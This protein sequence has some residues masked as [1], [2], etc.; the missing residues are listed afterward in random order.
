MNEFRQEMV[1]KARWS[2][3]EGVRGMDMMK[4]Y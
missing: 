2:T 3:K 4:I 1:D